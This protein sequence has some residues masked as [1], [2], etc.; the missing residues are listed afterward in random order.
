MRFLY[1][2]LL[3]VAL[4]AVSMSAQAANDV[5]RQVLRGKDIPA[6]PMA[7]WMDGAAVKSASGKD[8]VAKAPATASRYESKTYK[9]PT[10]T[11]E[12]LTAEKG[13]ALLRQISKET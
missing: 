6:V 1:T 13:G 4:S 2:A 9:F 8:A 10:G 3:G 5:S 11:V 7:G 12:V